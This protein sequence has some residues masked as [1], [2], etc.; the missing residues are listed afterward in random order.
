MKTTLKFIIATLCAFICFSGCEWR[1]DFNWVKPAHPSLDEDAKTFVVS[2]DESNIYVISEGSQTRF[3]ID[4]NEKAPESC[5]PS[6]RECNREFNRWYMN[7]HF[8]GNN[9]YRLVRVTPG[10]HELTAYGR[11]ISLTTEAG[12]NYFMRFIVRGGYWS[13]PTY[14]WEII[15]EEEGKNL[16]LERKLADRLHHTPLP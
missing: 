15:G 12:K 9:Q 14:E 3:L 6:M 10:Y 4:R 16:V 2:P 11:T 5:H 1:R 8:I 13:S 7:A